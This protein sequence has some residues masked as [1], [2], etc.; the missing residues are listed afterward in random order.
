[1]TT[2]NILDTIQEI[3]TF[4]SGIFLDYNQIRE[5]MKDANTL[6]CDLVLKS[7]AH[8]LHRFRPEELQEIVNK[9]RVNLGEL[10]DDSPLLIS[11]A[12]TQYP[13]YADEIG[14]VVNVLL[15][16]LMIH[17]KKYG[18]EMPLGREFVRLLEKE[19]NVN[20]QVCDIVFNSLVKVLNR[21]IS[22]DQ[23]IKVWDGVVKLSDLFNSELESVPVNNYFDQRFIDFLSKNTDSLYRIHWRKFEELTA[24]FF[25]RIGFDVKI[26]PGRGDGGVDVYAT[27]IPTSQVL[28][29]QCKRHSKNNEVEVNDVKALYFDIIDKNADHA[30]IATT[31][32][33]T[34]EGRRITASNYPISA[35]EH[36]TIVQWV[37][38]METLEKL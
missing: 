36:D 30:L 21:S 16:C 10:E 3:V 35:A 29:I 38:N 5:Y 4:K 19:A 32:K 28:I 13:E 18:A 6:L 25:E 1:M 22:Y 26:G 37:K 20:R 7:K 34:P 11:K 17:E 12:I 2:E 8:T 14:A 9:I 15:P 27:H 24:E 33:L 31:S 23:T